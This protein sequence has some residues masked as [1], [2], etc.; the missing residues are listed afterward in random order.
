MLLFLVCER[1][2]SSIDTIEFRGL[3]SKL[4]IDILRTEV[5]VGFVTGSTGVVEVLLVEDEIADG[6]G[7][8]IVVDGN[9]CT[10]FVSAVVVVVVVVVV[11]EV[12]VSDKVGPDTDTGTTKNGGVI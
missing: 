7:G 6:S 1:K 8:A 10:G 11:V 4:T 2:L 12:L 3:L 9:V 5:G